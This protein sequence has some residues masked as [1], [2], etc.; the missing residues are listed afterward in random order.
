MKIRKKIP[1]FRQG[2]NQVALERGFSAEPLATQILRM[3]QK[4]LQ[5]AVAD[6]Q[7]SRSQ[8]QRCFLIFLSVFSI[9]TL[10]WCV[11]LHQ[12]VMSRWGNPTILTD[13]SFRT[14]R[15]SSAFAGSP[16]QAKVLASTLPTFS[17][18]P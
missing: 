13:L 8:R 5:V 12:A 4:M 3:P 18:Q 1:T 10:L 14:D 2:P 6:Q 7:S 17:I 16:L 11:D 15:H 9:F